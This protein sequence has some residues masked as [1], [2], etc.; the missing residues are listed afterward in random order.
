VLLV[1]GAPNLATTSKAGVT[2]YGIWIGNEQFTEENTMIYDH[3]GNVEETGYAI[4]DDSTKTITFYNFE[5]T[6]DLYGD[7]SM[8]Y[9]IYSNNT[10][11]LIIKGNAI[12]KDEYSSSA[13]YAHGDITI[14]EDAFKKI[15]S[16]AVVKVPKKKLKLYKTVLKK[17]GISGKNQKIKK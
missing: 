6:K 8:K 9:Q 13:I 3:R 14:D 1:I 4:Y 16:K 12:L 11:E 17:A 15:H 5:G 2:E 7:G 10:N